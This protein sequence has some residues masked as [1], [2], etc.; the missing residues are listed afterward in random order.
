MIRQTINITGTHCP[1]CKKLIE[2]RIMT[3]AGVNSVDVNFESGK[4]V[5]ES[6][7]QI[8]KQEI[9]KALEGTDYAQKD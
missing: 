5:I 3:I 7:R 8:Y 2:K 6:T 1:A 9:N 4:T